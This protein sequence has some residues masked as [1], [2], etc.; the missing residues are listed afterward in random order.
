MTAYRHEFSKMD[1]RGDAAAMLDVESDLVA[2]K[3]PP[4]GDLLSNMIRN[5]WP[6]SIKVSWNAAQSYHDA[7]S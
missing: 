2:L 6:G 5:H 3:P 4:D 7:D 1:I